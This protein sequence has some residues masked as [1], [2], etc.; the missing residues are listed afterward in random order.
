[1]PFLPKKIPRRARRRPSKRG[2][3]YPITFRSLVVKHPAPTQNFDRTFDICLTF[4][5]LFGS[6]WDASRGS[7]ELVRSNFRRT[8]FRYFCW[9]EKCLG[10]SR[11]VLGVPRT[12]LTNMKVLGILTF[13]NIFF[14][15]LLNCLLNWLLNSSLYCWHKPSVT[16]N[17]NWWL[18]PK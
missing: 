18:L 16:S 11:M 13:F 12:T 17:I 15:G 7:L 4:L 2:W 10:G 8:Y 5:K 14:Y 6:I 3:S 9:S 1:M